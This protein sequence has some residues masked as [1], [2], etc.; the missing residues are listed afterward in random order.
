[1]SRTADAESASL[2]RVRADAARRGLAIEPVRLDEGTRTAAEAA[3]ACGCDDRPDRQVDR[4]PRGGVGPSPAV[5]DR[6]R[7]PRR[8]GQGGAAWPARRSRRPTP[9]RSAPSPASRSAASRR[10][11][12]S[13]RSTPGSTRGSSTSRRSGPPPARRTTSFRSARARSPRPSAPRSPTSP[14]EWTAPSPP[15]PGGSPPSPASRS[16]SCSRSAGSSCGR[17]PDRCS[18]SPRTGS[19]SSTRAPP[20]SPS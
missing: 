12:T 4:V 5:P 7:Q 17:W 9:P 15:S 1:M 16:P 14:P 3:R 19:S 18:A 10:S 11:A 6:R 13:R 2:A 20:S 8:P